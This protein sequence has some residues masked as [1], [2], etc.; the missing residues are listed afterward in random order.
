MSRDGW[1]RGKRCTVPPGT[2]GS[3]L[4]RGSSRGLAV[5]A[6]TVAATSATTLMPKQT[7]QVRSAGNQ[8]SYLQYSLLALIMHRQKLSSEFHWH[9]LAEIL[10]PSWVSFFLL[11]TPPWWQADSLSA[12][13]RHGG[14]NSWLNMIPY[15]RS[16]GAASSFFML[17]YSQNPIYV[18]MPQIYLCLLVP[19]HS[20]NCA[21]EMEVWVRSSLK[22][23]TW[24]TPDIVYDK[25]F[26]YRCLHELL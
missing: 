16:S 8:A 18:F 13:D 23:L 3:P 25:I 4:S 11:S 15:L 21:L 6:S 22:P 9:Q 7:A 12:S 10:S 17:S 19:I 5:T 24:Q 1:G 14:E 2:T 26:W 20:S